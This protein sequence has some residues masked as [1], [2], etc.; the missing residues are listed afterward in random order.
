MSEGKFAYMANYY[1]QVF[2]I[3]SIDVHMMSLNPRS[4]CEGVWMA[5][6][7]QTTETEI[8]RRDSAL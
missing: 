5:T 1:V 4:T 6:N 7:D 2:E 3:T 8:D